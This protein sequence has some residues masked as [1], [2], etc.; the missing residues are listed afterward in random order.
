MGDAQIG[1]ERNNEWNILSKKNGILCFKIMLCFESRPAAGGVSP[2]RKPYGLSASAL[3]GASEL[4]GHLHPSV[5]EH[6]GN[7]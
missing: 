1:G 4:K 7:W 5:K 2:G 6:V 3:T